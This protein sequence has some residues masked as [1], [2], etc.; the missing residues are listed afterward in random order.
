MTIEKYHFRPPLNISETSPVGIDAALLFG[1]R[2]EVP[3]GMKKDITPEGYRDHYTLRTFVR[4]KGGREDTV[5]A[6]EVK[7]R[8]GR[9]ISAAIG[10]DTQMVIVETEKPAATSIVD[11]SN[12]IFILGRPNALDGGEG[13]RIDYIVRYVPANDFE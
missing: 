2:E 1:Q 8:G 7:R 11:E 5:G 12:P 3:P 13:L 6:I 10:T 9:T 4:E